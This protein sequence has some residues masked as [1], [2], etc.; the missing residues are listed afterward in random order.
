[1]AEMSAQAQSCQLLAPLVL[2]KEAEEPVQQHLT[3]RLRGWGTD[4]CECQLLVILPISV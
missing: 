1:M 4:V 2:K 3:A